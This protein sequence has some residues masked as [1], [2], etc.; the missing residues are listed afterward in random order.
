MTTGFLRCV[1]KNLL[2]RQYSIISFVKY[3]KDIIHLVVNTMHYKVL[4]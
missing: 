1:F 3:Y 4:P 2:L